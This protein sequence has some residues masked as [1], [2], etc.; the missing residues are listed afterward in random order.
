MTAIDVIDQEII[1]VLV[2]DG[3]IAIRELAG[4]VALSA[5]ATSER[6][7]RL[8]R[9]GVIQG[10]SARIDPELIGRPIQAIVEVQ[11][12]PASG[13]FE[14][15]EAIA[16]IPQVVDAFHVTGRFDYQLRIACADI[17]GIEL[18]IRHL[19]EDLGVRETSTRVILRTVD[20]TPKPVGT[21]S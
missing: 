6:V 20:G 14:I 8:E 10:Y 2:E 12:D 17:E 18:A 16:A 4:R 11:L 5:S 13:I 21:P 3:R 9:S 1:G 19:K 15:D 7:R